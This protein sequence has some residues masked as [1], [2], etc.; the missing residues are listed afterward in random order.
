MLLVAIALPLL[1]VT[2]AVIVYTQFGKPSQYEE[3]YQKALT[4]A[5]GAVGQSD[6]NILR[7]AWDSTLDNLDQA[8][9]YQVTADSQALR[10]QA[11][12]G[13][14][15]LDGIIR[16]DFRPAIVGGLDE[17]VKVTGMAATGN[18][19][20]LLDSGRGL[21]LRAFLTSQGYEMDP[22][23][24]CEPGVYAEQSVGALIDLVAMPGGNMHNAAIAALD[25]NGTLVYCAP[26][27]DPL[28]YSL[29]VPGLG[30]EKILG[31]TL[32]ADG[33]NL[34]VLDSKA[35][36]IYGYDVEKGT[37]LDPIAFFG[38]QVPQNLGLAVDLAASGSDLY[39][40]YSDGHMTVCTFSG[41]AES[42]TTC[43]DPANFVDPRLGNQSGPILADAGFSQVVFDVPYNTA[44][45][46]LEPNTKGVY[47]FNPHPTAL[48][49]LGQLHA[50]TK[51]EKLTFQNIP[52]SALA[53]DTNRTLFLCVGNQVYFAVMP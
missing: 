47:K 10:Q 50:S 29:P 7:L 6:P 12:T 41:L 19:L 21:V 3:N 44:L 30:W 20:Y 36:W 40:L 15:G 5:Q 11:Q 49:L 39:L 35:A 53:I 24:I 9:R 22:M 17:S 51:L 27:S 31:F 42:N 4:A 8:D 18:D 28:A 45:F 48:E 38:E 25:A 2:V 52:A 37:F 34:F 13:L 32:N 1:L 14:D 16:L 33:K 46:L 26:G 43:L 23:F